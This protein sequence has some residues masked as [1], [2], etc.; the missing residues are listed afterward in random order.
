VTGISLGGLASGLDTETIITQLMAVQR[1]P[2]T[3][4]ELSQKFYDQRETTL[5]DVNSRLKSLQTAAKD[6]ASVLSWGEKQTVESSDSLKV[7]AR[8]TGAAAAGTYQ[9]AVTKLAQAEQRVFSFGSGTLAA[10]ADIDVVQDDSGST[11]TSVHLTAGMT[12]QQVADAIAGQAGSL[13]SATVSGTDLVLTGRKTGDA[14][15]FSIAGDVAALGTAGYAV[16]AADAEYSINGGAPATSAS[17]VITA[18]PGLEL[19][20]KGLTPPGS[21]VN[22]AVTEPRT[23]PSAV[24]DKLKAFVSQYNSTV[25]FVRSKVQEKRVANATTVTDATKGV[26][27]A[28][29]ALNGLL[30]SLR[31]A[32]AD[33]VSGNPAALDQLA[34][35]GI[36]TGKGSG[37]SS[38]A[39]SLA[40]KL[41]IDD[42]K[43]DS[44]LASNPD[45]VRQLLGAVTG[46]NGL[47]Q[48]LDGILNPFTKT[49]GTIDSR[50]D[51]A[52]GQSK[53]LTDQMSRLDDRLALEEERLRKQFT[54]LESMLSQSQAQQSWLTGQLNALG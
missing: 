21:P 8:Q 12:A 42:A 10:D 47:A 50:I 13:V 7:A 46:K 1:Q 44:V 2:R 23:D 33:P 22:V 37:G 28:D 43:L 3:R 38:S 4:L 31:S 53:R 35:L 54:A 19:T 45:G 41:V 15:G 26:L 49:D 14:N 52:D 17:N 36:T 24:K 30:S 16:D 6:L 11:T 5:G 25:D 27:Y 20:L 9:V 18:L 29:T 39:D 34:E 32:V 48:K 51:E 40:G